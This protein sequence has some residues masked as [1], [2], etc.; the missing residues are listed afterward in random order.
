MAGST[1]SRFA[2]IRGRGGHLHGDVAAVGLETV[3]RGVDALHVEL[4]E[5]ADLAAAVDVGRHGAALDEREAG[6]L[7]V[8]AQRVDGVGHHGLHRLALGVGGLEGL[9]V[10]GLGGQGGL[11]DLLGV[12]L[13]LVVHA[14]EVG[15][16]VELHDGA[17]RGVVGD[18]GHDRALVGGA[19]GLLG[20]GGQAGVAQDVDGLFQVGFGLDERLLALHHAGAGHLAELLDQGSGDLSH[21]VPFS[22]R[23]RM[24]GAGVEAPSGRIGGEGS[25]LLS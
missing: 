3:G 16:A 23:R 12:G 18:D 24:R 22:L 2:A 8:L 21:V 10:G 25:T 11:G 13:E 4:H 1:A 7:D 19:A 14:H 5:H 6:Q 20:N 17:R 9:Q 15:L